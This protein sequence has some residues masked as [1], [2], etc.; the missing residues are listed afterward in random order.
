V[1]SADTEDVCLKTGHI[2]IYVS[3]KCQQQFTPKIVKWLQ[4]RDGQPAM[5]AHVKL[6]AKPAAGPVEQTAAGTKRRVRR[7]PK[8]EPKAAAV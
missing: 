1:G 4:Q 3:S 7:T 2:G 8:S 6:S 5:K